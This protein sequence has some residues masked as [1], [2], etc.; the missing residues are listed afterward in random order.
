M[1]MRAEEMQ[2]ATVSVVRFLGWSIDKEPPNRPSAKCRHFWLL[3]HD[4]IRLAVVPLLDIRSVL[5]FASASKRTRALLHEEKMWELLR[6]RDVFFFRADDYRIALRQLL[7]PIRPLLQPDRQQR[8]SADEV[9]AL[10]ER[11][12]ALLYVLSSLLYPD[13]RPVTL[14]SGAFRLLVSSGNRHMQ[15]GCIFRKADRFGIRLYNPWPM[16]CSPRRCLVSRRNSRRRRRIPSKSLSDTG[17]TRSCS[18]YLTRI[19]L[20]QKG[21]RPPL[22][23][24]CWRRCRVCVCVCP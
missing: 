17:V 1:S 10:L 3:P 24:A 22:E 15:S 18:C 7:E 8:W 13:E 4:V 23:A 20:F 14:D 12:K 11:F 2:P 19:S 5:A 9:P 16:R 21:T 6:D